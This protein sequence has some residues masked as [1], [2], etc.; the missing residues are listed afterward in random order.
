MAIDQVKKTV[1]KGIAYY[2]R[3]GIRGFC[4]RTVRKAMLR[5]PVD[6]EK[7]L[8]KHRADAQTLEKQKTHVMNPPSTIG[9]FILWNSFCE[10]E[11]KR[12]EEAIKRQTNQRFE[13]LKSFE[14][15]ATDYI[16]FLYA[17]TVLEPDALYVMAEEIWKDPDIRLFYTDHDS[18]RADGKTFE[19]PSCTPSFDLYALRSTNYI[20]RTFLVSLDLVKKVGMPD[21]R[22]KEAICYDYLL[23]CAEETDAVMRIPKILVHEPTEFR[24]K[25]IPQERTAL[26]EHYKRMM[27]E[28]QVGPT[29]IPGVY[30]T[31]FQYEEEPLL[32]V[33]IPN[34]D[35]VDQL[36]DCIRSIRSK[37]GYD[38][39]EI[40]IMENGSRREETFRYYAE[41]KRS[42]PR[43]KVIKWE[44]EFQYSAINNDAVKE[45]NGEYLL[46][47]NN[48]TKMK[49]SGC[50][51]ELMN[52]GCQPNVGAVGARLYYGD[53]TIQHAG[54]VLGYG[55][56]AGHAFEGMSKAEYE[57]QFLAL[58]QRQ[59][60]AVTAACMLVKKEAFLAAGGFSK[61]LGLA[62]NDIDLCL[63]MRKEG[64]KVIY[65][66]HAQLYHYESQTRGLEMTKEKAE[67]VLQEQQFFQ[68]KWKRELEMGDPFYNPNLT[69]EKPDFSLKR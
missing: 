9:I 4:K 57:K 40:L 21:W 1:D 65:C 32:S 37:G 44:G 18:V 36:S 3:N 38:N 14:D 47:L 33:I 24:M 59:F 6:Y 48:D 62:Y 52:V 60:S 41:L 27:L 56:I 11:L 54:V 61:D 69:L 46:F 35:H 8:E 28:A 16:L 23:R 5:K 15:A 10:E 64:Y 63:S 53:D 45:A 66:P 30:H 49:R 50:L 17:G 51:A 31:Y 25:D 20:G 29:G 43:L 68:K 34:R 19:N 2:K 13:I 67:R 42:D 26:R 12:T 58:A 55:G 7:W 39:I 22:K